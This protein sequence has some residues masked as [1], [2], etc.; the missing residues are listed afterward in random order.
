MKHWTNEETNIA[1][2][3]LD[4]GANDAAFRD[5]LGRS[6]DSAIARM[7]RITYGGLGE[8]KASNTPTVGRAQVSPEAYAD[9]VRR[10]TAPRTITAT[11]LGDPAPGWS[12]LDRRRSA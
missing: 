1:K 3:L 5:R 12:M 4:A 6:K 7:D 10:L 9:A 8:R 11:L 2:Q